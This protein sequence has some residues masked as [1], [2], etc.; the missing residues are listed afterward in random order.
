MIPRSWHFS[1]RGWQFDQ[2][3]GSNLSRSIPKIRS[4]S[5]TSL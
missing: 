5:T 2:T 4:S 1:I 3:I